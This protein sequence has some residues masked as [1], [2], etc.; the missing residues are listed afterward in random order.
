[1]ECKAQ[2]GKVEKEALTVF[3]RSWNDYNVFFSGEVC[4]FPCSHKPQI[5]FR[6]KSPL[7]TVVALI[8]TLQRHRG[9]LCWHSADHN[10]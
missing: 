7:P 2:S 5:V 10:F 3:G 6:F 4:L 9:W 8:V 1:M